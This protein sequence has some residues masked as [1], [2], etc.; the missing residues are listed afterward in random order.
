MVAGWGVKVVVVVWKGVKVVVVVV[1]GADLVVVHILPPA[2]RQAPQ[3]CA[4]IAAL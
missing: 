3:C 4:R 1:E 2:V